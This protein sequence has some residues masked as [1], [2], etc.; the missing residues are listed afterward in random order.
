MTNELI[1]K[2]LDLASIMSY[3]EVDEHLSDEFVISK[4]TVWKTINEV[5][6]KLLR[7]KLTFLHFAQSCSIIELC[8]LFVDSSV[9]DNR[10][11]NGARLPTE[12]FVFANSIVFPPFVTLENV[13]PSLSKS[14]FVIVQLS[15]ELLNNLCLT[16]SST[17]STI[18]VVNAATP[19]DEINTINV[20]LKFVFI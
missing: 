16:L 11:V 3:K 2:M 12:L 1:I 5:L 18:L 4:F 19:H 9:T 6:L 13:L 7:P 17:A 20:D 8:S 14:C 15:F 10:P